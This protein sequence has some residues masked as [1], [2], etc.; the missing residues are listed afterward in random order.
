ML[1][2]FPI[3]VQIPAADLARARSFY[4]SLGAEV[5]RDLGEIGLVLSSGGYEFGIYPSPEAGQAAHTLASWLV[6]DLDREMAD[7]RERGIV[8]E[9]YDLPSLRTVNGVADMG[10]ER[11][12]WFRD[13]EGNILAVAQSVE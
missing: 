7:L 6:D 9:E 8:F 2:R 5:V 11:A 10:P 13:S 12:A 4:E 3:S 1:G